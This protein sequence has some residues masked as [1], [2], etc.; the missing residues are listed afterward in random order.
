MA[1][2]LLVDSSWSDFFILEQKKPYFQ[3]LLVNIKNEYQKYQCFPKW[4]N[5]F[6]VFSLTPLDKVKVVILGQ[7]PYHQPN[8]AH[9]LAFSVLPGITLPS[10]LRN[11]FQELK[12][13]LQIDNQE[14]GYLIDWA[15]EGV[16]LLNTALTVRYNSANSHSHYNWNVFTDNVLS[17]L[18][19]KKERL[20]FILWGNNARQKKELIDTTKHLIVESPH[21]SFFSA[22]KG[23][24]G[25]K[26]FSKTNDWLAANN[27]IPI[28]WKLAKSK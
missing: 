20:V 23:F 17:Y 8:Q 13:D 26:P 5:I 1:Q 3:E 19:E 18:N 10:S 24:F 14:T 27:Q 2:K 12:D 11:I 6:Q 9:G 7:D 4:D 22:N 28:N 15:K 21:P 16:F 25:S